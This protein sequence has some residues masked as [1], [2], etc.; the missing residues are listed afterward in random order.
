M[1]STKLQSHSYTLAGPQAVGDAL[2][3][4]SAAAAKFLKA[5]PAALQPRNPSMN[6]QLSPSDEACRVRELALS[7]LK[8]DPGF[9]AD[10]FAAADR[11]EQI[12][13]L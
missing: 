3:E 13:G 6:R 7:Y 10:L 11:H 2:N 1:S 9:A 8:T 5:L 4:L 12:H